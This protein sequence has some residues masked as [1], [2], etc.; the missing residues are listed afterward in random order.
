VTVIKSDYTEAKLAKV[1]EGQDAIVS[2]VGASGFAEQKIY[3]DAAVKAG[4]KRFI[5][6]EFSGN[7]PNDV[8]RQLVP[9]FEPKK[10]ILDYLRAKEATGMSWTGLATGLLFDWVSYSETID[11]ERLTD[12]K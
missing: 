9:A 11:S 5:P 3:I 10:E 7:T 1:F 4:V 8:V 12:V 6:S 2:A